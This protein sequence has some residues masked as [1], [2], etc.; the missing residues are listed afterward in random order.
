MRKVLACL[1]LCLISSFL[2]FVEGKTGNSE[3]SISDSSQSQGL[4]RNIE[5][6]TQNQGENTQMQIQQ[7]VEAGN[8]MSDEEESMQN[9]V[10][11]E[12]LTLSNGKKLEIQSESDNQ[13]KLK[14]GSVE[15]KTKMLMKQEQTE[16]GVKLQVQLSNG[17]NSEVKIMP[18]AASERALERLRIKVCSVENNCVIELKEVGSGENAK[19]AYEIKVQKQAKVLGIFQARMQVQAQVDAENGEVIQVKRPWWAFLAV[20]SEE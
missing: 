19:A 5:T 15:A 20:E 7:Q 2:F 8:P 14:S 17:K 9:S 10:Q 12:V 16:E 11:S 1:Y 3:I 6:E 4:Q 18:D 13:V